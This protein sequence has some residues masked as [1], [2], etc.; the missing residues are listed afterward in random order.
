METSPVEK[1]V[2]A[3]KKTI[4]KQ[5]QPKKAEKKRDVKAERKQAVKE[6]KQE[7]V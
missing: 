6:Q 7:V 5:E 2:I 4:V 1:E 3:E